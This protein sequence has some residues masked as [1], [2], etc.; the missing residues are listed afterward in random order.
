M[1]EE[2]MEE[3]V[4][5]EEVMEEEVMSSGMDGGEQ[6]NATKRPADVDPPFRHLQKKICSSVVRC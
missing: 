4:M 6:N 2:V 5:E 3:E 1:E